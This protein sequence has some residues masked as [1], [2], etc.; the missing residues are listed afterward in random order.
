[1]DANPLEQPT[2][3]PTAVA[4]G[5]KARRQMPESTRRI[6]LVILG[7]FILVGSVGG[8]YLTS[9]AFDKRT[10]VLVAAVDIN[11][12]DVVSPDYFTSDSAV[13]GSIPHIPYSAAA[14]RVADF[15]DIS[16]FYIACR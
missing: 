4:T 1:M 10:S 11:K 7:L 2:E 13:M 12:G 16:W 5:K 15:K 14:T 3:A 6:L 8:F 9:D